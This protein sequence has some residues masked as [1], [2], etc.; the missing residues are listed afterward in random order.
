MRD[1]ELLQVPLATLD[2][3]ELARR[4]LVF[5]RQVAIELGPRG[6]RTSSAFAIA[7]DRGQS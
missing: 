1:R 2:E 4:R 6:F 7:G 3:R 5:A